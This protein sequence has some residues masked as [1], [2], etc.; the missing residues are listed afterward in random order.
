MSVILES[1]Q[2]AGQASTMCG[3][4]CKTPKYQENWHKID[5]TARHGTAWPGPAQPGPAPVIGAGLPIETQQHEVRQG[6]SCGA[7]EGLLSLS[8]ECR[9]QRLDDLIQLGR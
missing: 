4:W 3:D 7:L 8:P 6:L 2:D 1:A 5:G 9:H